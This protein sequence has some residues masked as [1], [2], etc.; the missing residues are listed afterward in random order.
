MTTTENRGFKGFLRYFWDDYKTKT[1]SI[2]LDGLVG[3]MFLSFIMADEESCKDPT[4]TYTFFIISCL[5]YSCG[6]LGSITEYVE[7]AAASDGVVSPREKL[8]QS[9][10]HLLAHLIRLCQYPMIVV[11]GYD[12]IKMTLVEADKWVHDK[13]EEEFIDDDE[14]KECIKCFCMGSFVKIGTITFIMQMLYGTFELFFTW[15]MWYIDD[16]DDEKERREQAE[17]KEVLKST[18][19]GRL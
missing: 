19:R 14:T 12:I 7:K 10:C 13:D 5:H 3:G 15:L 9:G 18:R 4:F 2:Y 6:I 17:F 16:D 11:L 1:D 8:I